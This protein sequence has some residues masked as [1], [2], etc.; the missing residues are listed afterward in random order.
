MNYKINPK[1]K[2]KTSKLKSTDLVYSP[3]LKTILMVEKT[4]QD[5]PETVFKVSDIKR[6]LPK[7]VNHYTLRH[8]LEY[9]ENSNKIYVGIKG[10]TWIYNKSK[11]LD[12]EIK[13]GKEI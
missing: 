8:I 7:K 5:I 4:L 11:K 13:K 6:A 1:N 10:I 9:L 12:D 2:S 3:T